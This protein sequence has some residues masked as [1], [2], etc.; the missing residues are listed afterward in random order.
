MLTVI[1]IDTLKLGDRSYIAHDGTTALVIDPQR[2]I[3]RIQKILERE[4]LILGA[5]VETHMHNDYVS[6][7]LQLAREHNVPY[8]V[9]KS[10]L[11]SYD[12]FSVEDKQ[13]VSVGSFA[14]QAVHT[15]GHTYTHMSYVLLDAKQNAQGVFTGGSMLH[16][17]TGR[18]DLLG[19]DHASELA[20]LQHASVRRIAALLEDKISIYPT[21]G[22][23]S[24]CSATPTSG[25][26][27][28]IAEE[29][30]TNPALTLEK[31]DYVAQ[32]L[33]ALDAFPSYFKYMGPINM[34]GPVPLDLSEL[35][36]LSAG[37]VI[38]LI[39]AGY[40]VADLRFRTSWTRGHVPGTFSF[41]LDGS[42]ASYLGWLFPVD[43]KLI[44]V[45]DKASDVSLARRELARIGID[46]PEG[47]YVGDF[48]SFHTLNQSRTVTFKELPQAIKEKTIT[49]LDV[50]SLSERAASHIALSINITLHEL[51]SRIE[52]IP[53]HSEIWVH[54]ASAYRATIAIGILE[55]SGIKALLINEPYEACLDV[56]GIEIVTGKYESGLTQSIR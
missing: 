41:G 35:N 33:T 2:D 51:A 5:V 11:V 17:S 48:S 39:A 55:K 8:I 7:G 44:L 24:F 56:A 10:D 31:H 40:W 25:D 30:K 42:M 49:V 13:I 3:D 19:N 47:S 18:P 22:F 50:R 29:R 54:C 9:S 23:G 4:E 28:T 53:Q 37:E 52:E 1:N 26:S 12:R 45:S 32:T 36:S 15:P 21:H 16:G 43:S 27:S 6:G 34:A 20:G 46:H 14:L 38:K